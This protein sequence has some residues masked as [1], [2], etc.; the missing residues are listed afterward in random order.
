MSI[1]S[2]NHETVMIWCCM[3]ADGC[4]WWCFV[5]EYYEEVITVTEEVYT[6]FLRDDF[7][8]IY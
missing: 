4:L 3:R 6:R 5:N 7:P 8:Q 2:A 1:V